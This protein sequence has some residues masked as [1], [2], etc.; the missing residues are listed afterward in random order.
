MQRANCH[1]VKVKWLTAREE[2]RVVVDMIAMMMMVADM[3]IQKEV[4]TIETTREATNEGSALLVPH[5]RTK[6]HTTWVPRYIPTHMGTSS[7]YHL[8]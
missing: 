2:P 5:S 3:R 4:G 6:Q 8:T 1:R 7:F